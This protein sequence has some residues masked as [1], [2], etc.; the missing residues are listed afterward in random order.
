VTLLLL[1]APRAAGQVEALVA[2]WD[3]AEALGTTA[4]DRSGNGL[5]L[6]LQGGVILGTPGAFVSTGLAAGFDANAQGVGTLSGQAPLSGLL[7]DLSLAAWVRVEPGGPWS[8]RRI[9]GGDNSA[10]SCG[11]TAN[12]L[13]FTT[14]GI[15]DY[16]LAV[17]YPTSTWFH[18]AYVFDA[19]HDVTFYVDGVSVGTVSGGAPANAANG[20]WL[21]G[22]FN[23][24]LEYWHGALDDVQVYR[25]TLSAADVAFLFQNP[26]AGVAPAGGTSFCFGDGSAT[27]CPCG[28]LS[29][30]GEGCGNSSGAGG[31]LSASGT[32]S[33]LAADLELQGAQLVPGR[34]AILFGGQQLLNGAG[35][36]LFGD[37]LRCVGDPL[38]RLGI[39][40][41]DALG[42]ARWAGPGVAARGGWAP[43]ETHRLQIWY[44]DPLGSPCGQGFNTSQALEIVVSP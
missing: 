1:L 10:W 5:D 28:N 21:L 3:F 30:A 4:G 23:G 7:D 26:G 9:F 12:G 33:L 44:Q 8:I 15:L 6:A 34:L 37:G 24:S 25:G 42:G 16:D 36:S 35:G 29:V 2:H 22:A 20:Q 11:V 39:R 17:G 40:Q 43:A 27:V 38:R 13:R 18:V 41:A 14:W 31:R 19:A 32:T